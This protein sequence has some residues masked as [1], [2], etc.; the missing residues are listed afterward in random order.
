[1]FPEWLFFYLRNI[2]F[3]QILTHSPMVSELESWRQTCPTK[4]VVSKV[5][6]FHPGLQIKVTRISEILILC[7]KTTEYKTT[8]CVYNGLAM[9]PTW[10]DSR[11]RKYSWVDS[12][13]MNH[14]VV[15]FLKWNGPTMCQSLSPQMKRNLKGCRERP[16]FFLT[17][18][19]RCNLETLH[20]INMMY[21]CYKRKSG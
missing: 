4:A 21:S 5:R 15:L 12:I 1:M 20:A 14:P 6:Q 11:S 2:R 7:Y 16:F 10:Q 3:L 8:W 9:Q 18:H 17:W 19:L 13:F